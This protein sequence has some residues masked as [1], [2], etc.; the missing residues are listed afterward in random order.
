MKLGDV[1][2][3]RTYPSRTIGFKVTLNWSAFSPGKNLSDISVN[4]EKSRLLVKLEP[5][6]PSRICGTS[7]TGGAV[8]ALPVCKD[9]YRS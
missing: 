9:R 7:N 8:I 3:I 5:Y 6:S 4:I 1:V 2:E